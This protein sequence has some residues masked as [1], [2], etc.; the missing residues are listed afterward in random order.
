MRPSE[1]E[2]APL[3]IAPNSAQSQCA[4]PLAYFQRPLSRNPPGTAAALPAGISEEQI[5]TEL[6]RPHTS[7]AAWSSNSAMNQGCT[8]ATPKIQA[9]AMPPRGV[10]NPPPKHIA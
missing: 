8:P 3:A 9:A 10:A 2:S 1:Q 6:S 7:C 4:Q 5:K